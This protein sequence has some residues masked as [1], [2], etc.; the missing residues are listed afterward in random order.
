[1]EQTQSN[2][3]KGENYDDAQDKPKN[4]ASRKRSLG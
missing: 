2:N 3:E 4:I 1:M